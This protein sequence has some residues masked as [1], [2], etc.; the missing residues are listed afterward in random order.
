MNYI[1]QIVLVS[2]VL[3]GV[4]GVIALYAVWMGIL[5]K[6][7]PIT[8]LRYTSIFAFFS[9]I[10]SWFSGGYYYVLYY[11]DAV[12]PII[13]EGAFPWAH[14]IFTETKEHIFLV[15]PF[16][17]LVLA[18]VFVFMDTHIANDPKLKRSIAWL[19]GVA[20]IIGVFITLAGI[21]ISG[22]AQ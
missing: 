15:L 21:V 11:G 2:H 4:V 18:L 10:F 6:K 5:K 22:G 8:F 3:L 1:F 16:V 17:S 14:L 9:I 13:K 7:P 20:T 19:A 12:K